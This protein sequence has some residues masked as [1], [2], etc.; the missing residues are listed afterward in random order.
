MAF[1]HMDIGF[2]SVWMLDWS[3]DGEDPRN[4]LEIAELSL[5]ADHQ[6]EIFQNLKSLLVNCYL[7][8]IR[9]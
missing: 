1:Y 4:A 2:E 8:W 7:I 5:Y 3:L 9:I 6:I